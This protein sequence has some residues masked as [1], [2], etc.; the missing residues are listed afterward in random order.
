MNPGTMDSMAKKKILQEL[1]QKIILWPPCRKKCVAAI[2]EKYVAAMLEKV[3][4]RH[5]GK[6]CRE[7][8]QPTF[9]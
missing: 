6:S 7:E 5:V 8:G 1:G 9:S 4:G 2:L 3:C